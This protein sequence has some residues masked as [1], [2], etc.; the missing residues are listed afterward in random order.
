MLF[1]KPIFIKLNRKW[2]TLATSSP[3]NQSFEDP[4]PGILIINLKVSSAKVREI[5]SLL[6][7]E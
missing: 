3:V 1:I 4:T 6:K 2:L 7:C 5:S